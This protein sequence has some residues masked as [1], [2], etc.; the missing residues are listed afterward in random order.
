MSVTSDFALSGR[1]SP[2][3]SLV[4]LSL[5]VSI[6][7][8]VTAKVF[9]KRFCAFENPVE[10]P[11]WYSI[12]TRSTRMS[13][14]RRSECSTTRSYHTLPCHTDQQE[15]YFACQFLCEISWRHLEVRK[16]YHNLHIHPH[17]H[18]HPQREREREREREKERDLRSW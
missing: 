14:A 1:P 12:T 17:P 8:S 18:P 6:P 13:V 5:R 7:L 9:S 4:S 3:R 2:S 15:R 11:N 10:A 16:I